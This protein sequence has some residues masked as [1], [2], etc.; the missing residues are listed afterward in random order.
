MMTLLISKLRRAIDSLHSV[1][2]I[3]ELR[4]IGQ[5]IVYHDEKMAI[6]RLNEITRSHLEYGV[7]YHCLTIE[8]C[9]LTIAACDA[10]V[11]TTCYT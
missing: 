2:Q 8:M 6:Y 4:L 3:F 5:F 9:D 11:I 7:F 10:F 1:I